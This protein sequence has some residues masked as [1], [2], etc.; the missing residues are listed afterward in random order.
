[1]VK[2]GPDVVSFSPQTND[3]KS[4][5]FLVMLQ[6]MPVGIAPEHRDALLRHKQ[7]CLR[8]FEFVGFLGYRGDDNRLPRGK[9]FIGRW[10]F[11]GAL[12]RKQRE[13]EKSNIT[14]DVEA[15]EE[16]ATGV[17]RD[18]QV[19]ERIRQGDLKSIFITGEG[20]MG[21]TEYTRMITYRL[22]ERKRCSFSLASD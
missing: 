16:Q 4:G 20:G 9:C 5:V 22:V 2:C 3:S 15:D 21:K 18:E 19:V 1:M 12:S 14:E 7:R 8:E 13:K 10:T 6:R 17:L 11:D